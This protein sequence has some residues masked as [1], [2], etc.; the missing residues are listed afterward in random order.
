[1]I[2]TLISSKT[3]IKLLLKFFINQENA[4]YLRRLEQE[5]GESTNAIRVELN[6]LE[7]AGLLTSYLVGNKK[8]FK[9]NLHHP[10][11]SDLHNMVLKH[12]GLDQLVLSICES[13]PYMEKIYLT[14]DL[15]KGLDGG[16]ID[17]VFIGSVR[18]AHLVHILNKIEQQIGRNIRFLV[19]NEETVEN[20]LRP[21]L[22]GNPLLL[23]D[24]NQPPLDQSMTA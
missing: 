22:A 16:I 11:Y 1:M 5:F 17:L 4:S 21:A 20:T 9:A 2:E 24:K 7:G 15:S 18:K 6:R 14:G 23:Y 8:F 13:I 10:L 19:F 3:R 12:T